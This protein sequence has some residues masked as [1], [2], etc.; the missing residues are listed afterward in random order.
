[1][2]FLKR[3]VLEKNRNEL[4]E[5]RKKLEESVKG[6]VPVKV[7]DNKFEV[8]LPTYKLETKERYG[9][10]EQNELVI[11]LDEKLNIEKIS[12]G[13]DASSEKPIFDVED[14]ED[15]ESLKVI[16]SIDDLKNYLPFLV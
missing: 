14:F 1:M 5:S 11:I 6:E 15:V 13:Y 12:V 2:K 4:E 8:I 7:I 9:I 16:Y 3:N 10:A